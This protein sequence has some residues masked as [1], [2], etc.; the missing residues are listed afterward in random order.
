MSAPIR[1]A[2]TANEVSSSE[3]AAGAGGFAA[4]AITTGSADGT[5]L[6]VGGDETAL[7][8]SAAEGFFV[9]SVPLDAGAFGLAAAF[10]GAGAGLGVTAAGLAGARLDELGG[11]PE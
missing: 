9:V 7:L 8:P 2:V 1:S 4:P 10:G 3:G 5:L 11:A 6:G